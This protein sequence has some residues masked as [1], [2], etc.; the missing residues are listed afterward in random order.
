MLAPTHNYISVQEY[1]KISRY[2]NLEIEIEI[3]WHLTTTIV[4]MIVGALDRIKKVT[5][6]NINM[7]PGSLNLYEIQKF[8]GTTNLLRGVNIIQKR[9]QKHK[10]IEFL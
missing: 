1:H 5:D 9:Q 2:E 4:P 10:Y 8:C 6:K 3:V 7:T